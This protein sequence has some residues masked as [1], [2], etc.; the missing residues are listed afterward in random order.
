[1]SISEISPNVH[2]IDTVFQ[3]K[4]G[5]LASF[6]IKSDKFSLIDPGPPIQANQ[7]LNIIQ[8]TVEKIDLI[9]LTH[10]HLDHASGTWNILEKHPECRVIVHPRGAEHIVDPERLLEAAL[11]QFKGEMPPYGEIKKHLLKL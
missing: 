3:K 1:M 6:L 5:V 4:T 7:I 10:I 2:L 11:K 8:D 9:L